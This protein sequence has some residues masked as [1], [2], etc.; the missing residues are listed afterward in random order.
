MGRS[1]KLQHFFP[2]ERILQRQAAENGTKCQLNKRCESWNSG[3]LFRQITEAMAEEEGLQASS[4]NAVSGNAFRVLYEEGAC[5]KPEEAVKEYSLRQ[6]LTNFPKLYASQG[7]Y[8]IHVKLLQHLSYE[9][10]VW[11]DVTLPY[12]A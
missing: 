9:N 8:K 10:C 1:M 11:L 5:G 7:H 4:Q 6:T 3:R 2:R 12:F